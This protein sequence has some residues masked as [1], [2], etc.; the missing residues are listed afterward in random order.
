MC[1]AWR[2]AVVAAL[3]G[4]GF[5]SERFIFEGFLPHERS[6]RKKL[7]ALLAKQERTVACT[8]PSTSPLCLSCY[9]TAAVLSVICSAPHL[10]C[11]W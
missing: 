3:S 8:Y 5:P 7:L 11:V 6:K 9:S 2:A 10:C 4:S 1:L